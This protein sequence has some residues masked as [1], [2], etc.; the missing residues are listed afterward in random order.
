M[1]GAV[2]L[3]RRLRHHMHAAIE[4]FFAGECELRLSAA[5][6]RRE[7]FAEMTIHLVE[8][9]LQTVACF[10]VDA[11]DGIFERGHGLGQIF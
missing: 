1:N 3:A 2:F 7:H 4:N 9:G 10:A 6:Q 8:R 5:K 11:L